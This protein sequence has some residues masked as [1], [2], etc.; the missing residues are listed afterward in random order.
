MDEKLTNAGVLT[1]EDG[2]T[3]FYYLK[4]IPD[5]FK[6][7]CVKLYNQ[8]KKYDDVIVSTDMYS[9]NSVKALERKRRGITE[10]LLVKGA[11]TKKPRDWKAFLCN[12][13]NKEQ[14]IGPMHTCW[15]ELVQDDRR[16]LLIKNGEAFDIAKEEHIPDL[17]SNEE[18]TDSRVVLYCIYCMLQNRDTSM[19]G[20]GVQT[21]TYSGSC[22]IMPGKDITILFDTGHGNKK[23][24]INTT[25]SKCV[26]R[27]W[28]YMHS[29][30]VIQ[31]ALSG[32]LERLNLSSY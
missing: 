23:H 20:S 8:T 17:R 24:L 5:A 1:I 29:P 7:I 6:Q 15:S 12:E 10:K 32:V 9:T 27:C 19:Q 28:R 3:L 14:L 4:E 22:C 11:S 16:V 26:R 25:Q 21:V 30:V 2:N 18:E 13:E 31:S